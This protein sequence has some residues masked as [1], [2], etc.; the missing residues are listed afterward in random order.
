MQIACYS[1]NVSLSETDWRSFMTGGDIHFGDCGSDH[2][3]P[4][5]LKPI[6]DD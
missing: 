1:P 4:H 6:N 2:L 3:W 5:D